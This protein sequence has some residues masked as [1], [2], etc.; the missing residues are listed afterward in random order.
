[1]KNIGG[2]DFTN[3]STTIASSDPYI[4]ITD[5]SGYFGSLLV[6][7]TK[8]NTGDPYTIT[9]SGSAPQGHPA[10]FR[11]IA[12]DGAWSD[13]FDFTLVIGRIHYYIW[14]PD[15]TPALGEYMHTALASVG[16]TGNYG[17]NLPTSDLD[18]Y[19]AVFVCVGIYSNNYVLGATD[20]E[21]TALVDY[22]NNG[23][24][25]YLEG[26]DVWYYDPQWGGYNFCPLF[27]INATSDGTSDGGPYAGQASTF[28]TGMNFNYAGENNW[29]DHISATGT[30]FLIFRDSNNNYDCGVAN[31]A[32]TYRTVG[33]GFEL[34]ALTDASPPST[35]AALLDSIM[36][37]FGV[38]LVVVE[39]NSQNAL[40]VLSLKLSPNPF[41]N[42]IDIQYTLPANARQV[43]FKIFDATGRLVKDLGQHPHSTAPA[44]VSWNG[45]DL[46]GK[47]AAN[48]IYFVYMET[49]SEQLVEKIILIE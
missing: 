37:F 8:E 14:N 18:S 48:G 9:A 11:L 5:N 46:N 35:R 29:M 12:V 13:T 3:L 19:S 44:N 15:P 41:R 24:R 26:G 23:G 30:G 40:S 45:L 25:M 33:C 22:V 42:R 6:D 20:P 49:D 7:S 39:E 32:G 21:V 31:D 27:G 4:T 16:Y 34:G 1:M 36:R 2:A 10:L 47:K 17:L 43:R 28:T 38:N